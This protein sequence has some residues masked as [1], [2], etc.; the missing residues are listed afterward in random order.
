MSDE[1]KSLGERVAEWSR[2]P[3]GIAAMMRD[4]GGIISAGALPYEVMAKASRC[5]VATD[6]ED[7]LAYPCGVA[8]C[9]VHGEDD[10]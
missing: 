8:G 5:I 2:S 7:Y 6:S 10:E 1:K 9:P 4:E 3:E